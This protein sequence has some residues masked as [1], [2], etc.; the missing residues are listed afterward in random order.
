MLQDKVSVLNIEK[1]R[2]LFQRFVRE[3]ELLYG[4]EWIGINVHFLTHLAQCVLDWGCLWAWSTFIPEWFN[5][6][7][8][9]SSN[10]TQHMALQM[11]QNYLLSQRVRDK[12]RALIKENKL[13]QNVVSLLSEL[14]HLPQSRD[15]ILK[16]ILVN[17]NQV[18]L[19]GRPD[20]RPLTMDEEIA[21]K[22]AFGK[23]VDRR[24]YD[25]DIVNC[26]AYSRFQLKISGSI[27]TTT[28]YERSPKRVNY[29]AFLKDGNFFLID[30][31]MF[32]QNNFIS[33]A[34]IVG[35]KMGV[36]SK[37]IYLPAPIEGECFSPIPGQT[38]KLFGL[39]KELFAYDPI[40]IKAKAVLAMNNILTET[41]VATAIVNSIETD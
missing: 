39:S 6:Q 1:V 11:A 24:A 38:T 37:K 8:N 13:P 28:S 29:C 4:K 5:G 7:L 22:N 35:K 14:L 19:L 33:R 12:A 15:L 18:E 41:F 26:K 20:I 9:N 32:I 2:R 27:F 21:V 17:E 23:D 36:D 16:A 40:D 25:C 31:I 10:G 34:F 30:H 3:M